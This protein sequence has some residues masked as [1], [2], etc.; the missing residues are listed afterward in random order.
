M[1]NNVNLTTFHSIRIVIEE[2]N[3]KIV[4]DGEYDEGWFFNAETGLSQAIEFYNTYWDRPLPTQPVENNPPS[5]SVIGQFAS[6]SVLGLTLPADKA[7]RVFVTQYFIVSTHASSPSSDDV[8][9]KVATYSE[10]ALAELLEFFGLTAEELGLGEKRWI[11]HCNRQ[12][13]NSGGT[14]FVDG[15]EVT[16]LDTGLH[17]MSYLTDN[18]DRFY[19]KLIKHELTHTIQLNLDGTA[20]GFSPYR[21]ERWFS[22]GLAVLTSKNAPGAESTIEYDLFFGENNANP[23][24]AKHFLSIPDDG[25]YYPYYALALR[26]LLAPTEEGGAG[27]TLQQFIN[28]LVEMSLEASFPDAFAAHLTRNGNPLTVAEF[29]ANYHA[30]VRNYLAQREFNGVVN[31]AEG[32]EIDHLVL[33]KKGDPLSSAYIVVYGGVEGAR[34]A[35]D[36][37][38]VHDGHYNLYLASEAM[39][40]GPIEVTV[41]GGEMNPGTLSDVG[42]LPQIPR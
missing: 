3:S 6:A 12:T 20:Q 32:T 5:D 16:A 30:W 36:L 26:Y 2:E 8:L 29:E 23:I 22:E 34:F 13:P 4:F 25:L 1:V 40:F 24:S 33:K 19:R 41:S 27:N 37:Q 21:V 42:S 10:E 17:D 31:G 9:V 38:D 7:D 39:I 11:V 14:G 28:L 35:I 15:I 18:D